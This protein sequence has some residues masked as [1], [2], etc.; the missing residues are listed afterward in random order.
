MASST[1][2]RVSATPPLNLPDAPR[3]TR[4]PSTKV[5]EAQQALKRR[6][7]ALRLTQDEDESPLP[8]TIWDSALQEQVERDIKL[9]EIAELIAGLKKT[10]IQ[11]SKDLTAI[12]AEQQ[13]LK[14]QNVELQEAVESL[15]IQLDTLST[16]PPSTQSWASVASSGGQ[17]VPGTIPL[18]TTTSTSTTSNRQL[19]V[20]ASRVEERMA[21]KIANTKAAKD[22][23]QQ[24]MRCVEKLAG[25]TV[26]DFRVWRTNNSMSVIKF[27]IDKDHEA[28]A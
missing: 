21:E 27:S 2:G 14:N 18:Q 1:P 12:K 4:K 16:N 17:A 3:R 5:L 22:T 24:G 8:S 26:K 6:T 20:D 25:A 23:I 7:K 9:E 13:T 11:Q 28:A 19:V 15:R 10:I